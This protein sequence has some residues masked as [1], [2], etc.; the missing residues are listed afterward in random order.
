MF[1]NKTKMQDIFGLK[2][3][4]VAERE[5]TLPLDIIIAYGGCVWL[6]VT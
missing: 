4:K 6:S 5:T 3:A 1:I 2:I